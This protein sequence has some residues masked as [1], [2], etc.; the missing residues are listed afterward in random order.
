MH[1]HIWQQCFVNNTH[2]KSKFNIS[3][4]KYEC[5]S[6]CVC[7]VIV[8]MVVFSAKN[9]HRIFSLSNLFFGIAF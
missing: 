5:L 4:F 3:Y 8:V 7:L 2:V 1:C 9:L 6:A